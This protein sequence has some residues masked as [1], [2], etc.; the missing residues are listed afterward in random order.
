MV[1]P[2]N[3]PIDV[4]HTSLTIVAIEV[5]IPEVAEK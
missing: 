5:V 3:K 1:S 4:V 2:V